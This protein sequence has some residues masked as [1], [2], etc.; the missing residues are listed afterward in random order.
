MVMKSS[1]LRGLNLAS[2]FVASKITVFMTFMAYVLLG[3]AISASK[4]F[5]AVSLYGAVRLTVTLFFPSA[6]ER[7]SESL[8]SIRRIK[9]ALLTGRGCG[10]LLLLCL[11]F[12]IT[13]KGSLSTVLWFGIRNGITCFGNRMCCWVYRYRRHDMHCRVG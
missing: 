4:V 5:V 13:D 1:Y 6:V 12:S 3:E 11:C 9:V 2:F 7:V 8:I 10:F